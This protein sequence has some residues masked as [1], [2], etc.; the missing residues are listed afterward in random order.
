MNFRGCHPL[1]MIH[2]RHQP[3]GKLKQKNDQHSQLMNAL[4]MR[5]VDAKLMVSTIGMPLAVRGTIYKQTSDDMPP[6]QG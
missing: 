5:G 6:P 1:C 4:Q 3:F 2:S